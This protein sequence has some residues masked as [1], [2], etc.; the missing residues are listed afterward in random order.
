M[1][2]H[3]KNAVK[4]LFFA[5]LRE[6]AGKSEI[7]VPLPSSKIYLSELPHLIIDKEP[8]L[9]SVFSN[10]VTIHVALNHKILRQ[11]QLIKEGDEI[12]YFPPMTGG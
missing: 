2:Q 7:T 6:K 10:S 9:K 3:I 5:H 12:A 1:I 11:D 8:D 4:I